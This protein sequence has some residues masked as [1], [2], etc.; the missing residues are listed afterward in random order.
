MFPL[1][2]FTYHDVVFDENVFPFSALPNNSTTPTPPVHSTIPSP[3]QFVDVAYTPALLPN[4][5]AGIGRGAR[6]ELLDGQATGND[7][8][9]DADPMYEPCTPGRA[10]QPSTASPVA[11]MPAEASPAVT[12]PAQC[13]GLPL[14][15]APPRRLAQCPSWLPLLPLL[16][17]HLHPS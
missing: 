6:L 12:W 14:R 1:I 10:R 9:R 2:A 17:G 8:V 4:H 16:A 13:P 15:P 7:S 3:D 11:A 5:A